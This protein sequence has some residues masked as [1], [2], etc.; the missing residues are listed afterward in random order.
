[1]S[2]IEQKNVIFGG[3]NVKL[4]NANLYGPLVCMQF[5]LNTQPI[6]LTDSIVLLD[7]HCITSKYYLKTPY[8][9]YH[10]F[11]ALCYY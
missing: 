9:I 2:Q 3:M 10:L 6:P 4:G 8:N 11:M 7:S 1:M 5:H